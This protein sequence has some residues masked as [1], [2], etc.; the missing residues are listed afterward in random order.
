MQLLQ[1]LG[2]GLAVLTAPTAAHTWIECVSTTVPNLDAARVSPGNVLPNNVCSGYPRNK[3]LDGN[4]IDES[5]HYSW[6]LN[7]PDTNPNGLACNPTQTNQ[8]PPGKPMTTAKPGTTLMMRFWGNG[9]TSYPYGLPPNKDPGLVRIYWKGAKELE[10]AS[11]SELT[12]ANWLPG[13]QANFSGNSIWRRLPDGRPDDIANYMH[14]TLP[15]DMENGRHV[16]V[17][18]WAG[19]RGFLNNGPGWKATDYNNE[20]VNTYTTCFDIMVEGSSHQGPSAGSGGSSG[21]GGAADMCSSTPCRKGGM[22][23]A[24]CTGGSCPPCRYRKAD[25]VDCYEYKDGKCPF[26]NAFDCLLNKQV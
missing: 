17:F 6:N 18:A 12:G 11:K 25:G 1:L 13:A 20:W 9:H 16:M 15:A 23:T 4:W 14:F 26:G 3:A 5:T 2:L 19:E 8:Y 21:D 24:A 7:H 10:F 22:S